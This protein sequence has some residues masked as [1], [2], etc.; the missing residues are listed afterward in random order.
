MN[1]GQNLSTGVQRGELVP[2]LVNPG[3]LSSHVRPHHPRETL[4]EILEN[5]IGYRRRQ[6]L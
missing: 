4:L 2:N 6:S 1:F 3:F 5:I